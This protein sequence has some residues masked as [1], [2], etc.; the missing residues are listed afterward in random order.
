MRAGGEL[1][2]TKFSAIFEKFQQFSA[3]L[4]LS[5]EPELEGKMNSG[6]SRTFYKGDKALFIFFLQVCQI[7]LKF[8]ILPKFGNFVAFFL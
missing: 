1:R 3:V 7:L 2:T 4:S 5:A 6:F 8:S